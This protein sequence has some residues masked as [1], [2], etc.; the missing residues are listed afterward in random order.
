MKSVPPSRAAVELPDLADIRA[1]ALAKGVTPI[2]LLQ[3]TLFELR[4][5]TARES[6][7]RAEA[8]ARVIDIGQLYAATYR[9][10]REDPRF[11]AFSV[12]DLGD[13]LEARTSE[14][15]F[16]DCHLTSAGNALLAERIRALLPDDGP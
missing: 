8:S 6:A 14:I 15:F 10:I 3:P 1:L 13:A 4:H 5:P 16:D 12:H 11:E 2:F 9:A 7:L